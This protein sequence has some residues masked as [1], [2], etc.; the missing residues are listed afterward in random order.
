[1]K[2]PEVWGL[3]VLASVVWAGSVVLIWHM[4]QTIRHLT[5]K[6]GRARDRERRDSDDFCF[7]LLEKA[8]LLPRDS[9]TLHAKERYTRTMADSRLEQEAIRKEG[10]EEKVPPD[11]THSPELDVHQ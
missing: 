5:G 1:M 2:G 10:G 11:D 8:Q 7:R 9:S 4:C 3:V 6:A